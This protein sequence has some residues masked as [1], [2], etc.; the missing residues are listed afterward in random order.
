MYWCFHFV[1]ICVCADT[2]ISSDKSVEPSVLDPV[3]L[4]F[5]KSKAYKKSKTNSKP[6]SV[7]QPAD[8]KVNKFDRLDLG[9]ASGKSKDGADA[10]RV[11]MEKAKDYGK[12]KGG[13]TES[14]GVGSSEGSPGMV[15]ILGKKLVRICVEK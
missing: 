5:E 2:S 9:G 4:A 15:C 8:D 13:S 12:T 11:A 10:F 14:K 3:K 1:K 6:V 7:Q